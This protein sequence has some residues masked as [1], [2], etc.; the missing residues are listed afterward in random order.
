MKPVL[1]MLVGAVIGLLVRRYARIVKTDGVVAPLVPIF[2]PSAKTCGDVPTISLIR[3]LIQITGMVVGGKP[4]YQTG[5]PSDGQNDRSFKQV[6][7]GDFPTS[8]DNH[9]RTPFL[10]GDSYTF[11]SSYLAVMNGIS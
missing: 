10:S 5:F 1:L 6:I 3:I 4:G 2:D 8:L 11:T 9:H 7:R